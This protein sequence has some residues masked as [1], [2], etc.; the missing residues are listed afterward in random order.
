M[1]VSLRSFFQ[2]HS[3]R[4]SSLRTLTGTA[5]FVALYMA[6]SFFTVSFTPT[7]RISF[8]FLALAASCY[9]YGLGPNL[10]AAFACDFL[11]FVIHPEGGYVPFFA[12]I[13]MLNAAFYS[14]FFYGQKKV[15]LW[16]IL[17]ANALVMVISH[18][19]LNPLVLTL[20]YGTPYWTLLVTRL[21]K[22]LI[23][24]PVEVFL[25]VLTLNICSRIK[26]SRKIG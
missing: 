2:A 26:A 9:F 16:R 1:H 14:L 21:A 12:L 19:I 6:L 15:S 5:M 20:M 23:M 8:S 18:L 10:I 3:G 24:Y 25:L 7:L 4:I 11:G 13:L 17:A 22:N